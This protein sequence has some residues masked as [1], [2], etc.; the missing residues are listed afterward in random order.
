MRDDLASRVDKITI[1][2]EDIKRLERELYNRIISKS[3][4]DHESAQLYDLI[5]Y[6]RGGD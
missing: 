3:Q 4:Y 5:K 6:S 1:I 2:Y